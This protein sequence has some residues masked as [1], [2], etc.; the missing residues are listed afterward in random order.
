MTDMEARAMLGFDPKPFYSPT[1]LATHIDVD[2]STVMDW[3]HR[4]EL[5]AVKLGPKTYRIPLAAVVSRLNPEASRPK[6]IAVDA[7]DLTADEARLK[8]RPIAA[9]SDPANA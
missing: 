3:I 8:R 5:Y 6:R 2:P 4:G 1:E 9:R 7:A